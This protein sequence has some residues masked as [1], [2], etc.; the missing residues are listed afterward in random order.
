MT[1]DWEL[2]LDGDKPRYGGQRTRVR[3]QPRD[4]TKGNDQ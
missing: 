3:G 2:V 4:L 1:S